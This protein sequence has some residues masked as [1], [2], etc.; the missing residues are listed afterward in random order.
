MAEELAVGL[1]PHEFANSL[2]PIARELARMS[3]PSPIRQ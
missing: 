3:N 2:F 1:T